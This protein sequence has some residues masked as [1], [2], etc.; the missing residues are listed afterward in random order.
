MLRFLNRRTNVSYTFCR[1]VTL[2][3]EE[4][5]KVAAHEFL[6][7]ATTA[8]RVFIAAA[9]NVRCVWAD[10]RWCWTLKMLADGCMSGEKSLG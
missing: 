6:A 5:D 9:W 10:A 2:S 4:R 8:L 1:F 7:A 3:N